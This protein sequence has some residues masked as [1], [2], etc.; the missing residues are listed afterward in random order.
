MRKEEGKMKK[1]SCLLLVL[2]FVIMSVDVALAKKKK[3]KKKSV[4]KKVMVQNVTVQKVTVEQKYHHIGDNNINYF[5][6]PENEGTSWESSFELNKSTLKNA[7]T[8]FAKFLAHNLD[9][10]NLIVNGE[11]IFLEPSF[12]KS[13][14]HF[15][16]YMIPLPLNLFHLGE[17]RIGFQSNIDSKSNYDDMEFGELEIW[18]QCESKKNNDDDDDDD[19]D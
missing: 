7:H 2:F 3:K 16:N 11:P 10:T 13:Y 1:I 15:V 5:V 18:F 12:E 6:V 4:V 9:S 19:D 8:V 14:Q 17:N